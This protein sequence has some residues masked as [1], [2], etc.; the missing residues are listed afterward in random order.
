MD[1]I[2]RWG[3]GCGIEVRGGDLVVTAV[4]VRGARVELLGRT[5]LTSFRE[6]RPQ[7]WGA[8]Y[9]VLAEQ[10]GLTHLAV[11]LAFPRDEVILRTV[12][13]PELA[14]KELASAVGF[15]VDSLHPWAEEDVVHAFAPLGET[16]AGQ[17]SV[18][19][20]VARADAVNSY[21]RL[22]EEAGIPAA[23]FT[24][25]PAAMHAAARVRGEAGTG[26]V[27]YV[28]HD[29]D[30]VE[31]FGRSAAKPFVSAEFAG[32]AFTMPRILHWLGG[33]LRLAE[34]EPASAAFSGLVPEEEV[35]PSRF[36]PI[37]LDA[38]LPEPGGAIEGFDIARDAVSYAAALES[39]CP[40]LGWRANLL[41]VD[42]RQG[43]SRTRYIPTLVLAAL[44]LLVGLAAMI[45]PVLQDGGYVAALDRET[46]TLQDA[47]RAVD[48][49]RA[50]LATLREKIAVLE[51]LG[52][53]N[54][55]DLATLAE[56]SQ[57]LPDTAWAQDLRL[58]DEELRLRGEAQAASALLERLN[59][60]INLENAA[61]S[62]SLVRNDNGEVYQIRAQRAR[63]AD[64]RVE[65][66]GE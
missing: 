39:A 56:V 19:V 60:T 9:R 37:G 35:A 26:A 24:V 51:A 18:M 45:R 31:V 20:A 22:L 66:E 5:L 28:H 15:Q 65:E 21:A 2:E 16:K 8:E 63:A 40:R 33:E 54:A 64:D 30:G 47:V 55:L 23:G 62:S 53:R 50:E 38:L 46:S 32:S 4:R 34:D 57:V 13:L 58:N 48:R 25:H 52:E 29:D 12:E 6:R 3:T 59:S 44:L 27:A 41:P 14:P 36:E 7:E 17:Q 10:L 61:F 42:R 1:L 43:D 49:N 11:T